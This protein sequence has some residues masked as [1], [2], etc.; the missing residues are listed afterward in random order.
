LTSIPAKKKAA[1]GKGR[2]NCTPNAGRLIKKGNLKTISQATKT[3]LK[4]DRGGG[5]KTG[6]A[7]KSGFLWWKTKANLRPIAADF[8]GFSFRVWL[9]KE[10]RE[11][12][13]TSSEQEKK[14]SY[15]E[16]VKKD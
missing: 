2:G 4:Y 15:A 14:G 13:N 8:K 12:M 1:E 3:R 11:K 5:D 7:K 16:D 10:V 6:C 9:T